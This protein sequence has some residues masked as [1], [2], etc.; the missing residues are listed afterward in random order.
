MAH[1]TDCIEI[2]SERYRLYDYI[3]ALLERDRREILTPL[4]REYQQITTINSKGDKQ[5]G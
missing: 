1:I 5:D 3:N 4:E 2:V